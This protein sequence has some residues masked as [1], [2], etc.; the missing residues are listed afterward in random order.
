MCGGQLKHKFL[1]MYKH[2]HVEQ[3]NLLFLKS[4]WDFFPAPS[5]SGL[6]T[7]IPLFKYFILRS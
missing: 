4:S 1:S 6:W 5:P 2:V 7:L 3:N